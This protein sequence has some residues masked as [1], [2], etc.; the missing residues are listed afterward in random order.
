MELSVAAVRSYVKLLC[1][2]HLFVVVVKNMLIATVL[3]L[4]CR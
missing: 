3:V 2:G 1:F 4:Y